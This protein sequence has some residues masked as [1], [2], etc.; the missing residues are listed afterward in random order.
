MRLMTEQRIHQMISSLHHPEE[1]LRWRAKLSPKAAD[2]STRTADLEGHTQPPYRGRLLEGEGNDY[3]PSSQVYRALAAHHEAAEWPNERQRRGNLVRYFEA[4]VR[5]SAVNMR[6]W[7]LFK[8]STDHGRTTIQTRR[9]EDSDTM[10]C[11]WVRVC[12][13][14]PVQCCRCR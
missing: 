9:R 1:V 11:S 13:L 12:F 14:S 6:S 10:D 7:R 2:W 3:R 8:G 4:D 5:Q